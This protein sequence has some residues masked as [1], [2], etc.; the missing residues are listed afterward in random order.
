MRLG[1][2]SLDGSQV[3]RVGALIVLVVGLCCALQAAALYGMGRRRPV[4][5][6]VDY[7]A[8]ARSREPLAPGKFLRPP[9]LPLLA[10]WCCRL[11]RGDDSVRVVMSAASV[12]TVAF[13]TASALQLGGATMALAAAL[14]LTA[15]P[16]R[17]VLGCHVWPDTL[18]ALVLAAQMWILT[19]A[20]PGNAG[21][22]VGAI[23]ATVGVLVRIDFVIAVP[24]FALAWHAEHGGATVLPVLV[25][26]GG[27]LSALALLTAHNHRRYGRALPDD[28]W[29]FN[30]MV[31]SQS[32]RASAVGSHLIEP[33]VTKTEQEWLGLSGAERSRRALGALKDAAG[34]PGS[35]LR[36]LGRRILTLL[37]PDRFVSQMLLPTHRAYPELAGD[38]RGRLEFW[39]KWAFPA[40]VALGVV[41]SLAGLRPASAY[42]WPSLGLAFALVMSH[43]RTRYRVALLPAMSL[44]AAEGIDRGVR[45]LADHPVT[46]ALVGV[47]TLGL[48]AALS[49]VPSVE[50]IRQD[51][52]E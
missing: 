15:Q 36:G 42:L 20:L 9:A 29:A 41:T 19:V 52:G 12:L 17:M 26:V 35:L 7:L 49:R 44:V 33:V 1:L 30:L 37:G 27:P 40:L 13:T 45:M 16:E 24:L 10:A 11:G 3:G 47:A 50:E 18:I 48:A 8:N 38:W 14:L 6:E 34:S 31:M 22:V 2:D 43:T 23:L 39:L 32:A 46:V 21:L 28:T 51:V 25:L 5:D 4:G